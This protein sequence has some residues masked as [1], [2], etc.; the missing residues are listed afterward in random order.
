MTTY[1]SWIPKKI[2]FNIGGFA[3][4]QAILIIF[5]AKVLL[6]SIGFFFFF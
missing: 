3:V 1:T 5:G 6:E 4:F 2:D